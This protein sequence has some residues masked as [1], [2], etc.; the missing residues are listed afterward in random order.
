MSSKD[1]AFLLLMVWSSGRYKFMVCPYAML[2]KRNI[3]S[4]IDSTI[5]YCFHINKSSQASAAG[6]PKR[7]L[8]NR[9]SSAFSSS[10]IANLLLLI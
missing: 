5:S 6:S 9:L 4:Q 8:D 1:E 2:L 3:E 10:S 7:P